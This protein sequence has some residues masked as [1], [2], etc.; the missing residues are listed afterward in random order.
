MMCGT[1]SGSQA[2]ATEAFKSHERPP[3]NSILRVS[4]MFLKIKQLIK[5][6]KNPD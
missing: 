6:E 4:F 5:E 1:Y 3:W 2:M